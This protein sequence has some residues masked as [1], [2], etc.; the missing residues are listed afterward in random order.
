DQY[1]RGD[2]RQYHVRCLKCGMPQVLRFSGKRKDGTAWGLKWDFKGSKNETLDI[3]TVR[4]HCKNCDHPHMEHDKVRMITTENAY[5]EP[6]ADPAMPNCRSYQVT[7][8]MSRRGKWYSGVSKWLAAVGKDGKVK[9]PAKLKVFYNNFL[10]ETFQSYTG[11]IKF[12]MVSSHRRDWYHKGEIKNA[13]VSQYCDSEILFLTCTVDVHGDN[14]AAAVWGWARVGTDFT[15]WL[16]EYMRIQD[17]TGVSEGISLPE[18]PAWDQLRDLGSRI[19]TSDNEKR[20]PISLMFIDSSP[21]YDTVC[22]FCEP[23][24]MVFPIQG[25]EITRNTVNEWRPFTTQAGDPGWQIYVD[26]IK[27]RLAPVLRRNWR[28]EEGNQAPYTFNAPLNTSDDELKELTREAKKK[29]MLPNGKE[30]LVWHRPGNA[31]QELWDL[32]VYAHAGVE[33][34]AWL[35][36]ENMQQVPASQVVVSWADFW[37]E[38][39]KGLFFE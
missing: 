4:F 15:C 5:W 16:I 24:P 35:V 31:P 22:G 37:N 36:C 38:C 6:T 39:E 10:A 30:E 34:L 2:R 28:P 14:L 3:E 32:M 33:I 25:R 23:Y 26:Y 7:G 20:Y 18:S 8:M 29:K 12:E 17:G 11:R 1:L 9:S 19:W 21:Y 13:I 27:D